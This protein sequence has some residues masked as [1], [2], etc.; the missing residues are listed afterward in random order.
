M[1]PAGTVVITHNDI[2]GAAAAAMVV[3]KCGTDVNNVFPVDYLPDRLAD[4]MEG[5]RRASGEGTTLFLLDITTG[6]SA[7]DTFSGLVRNMK[8]KGAHVAWIDHHDCS[9]RAEAI[10]RQCDLAVVGE[11]RECATELARR[12]L[13]LCGDFEAGLGKLV[14]CADFQVA[15]E[16]EWSVGGS[17]ALD[18]GLGSAETIRA[19][20]YCME[21]INTLGSRKERQ[22]EFRHVVGVLA[23]GRFI[24]ERM[25]ITS[26]RFERL[27]SERIAAMLEG[28]YAIS[29]RISVGFSK[30]VESS[31]ACAE[32][33]A[34]TGADIGI[35]VKD[36]G[37]VSIRCND[38]W[39]IIGLARKLGGGGHPHA[40][41][42]QV[43]RPPSHG[44]EAWRRRL[45]ERIRLKA[46]ELGM[47]A[48]PIC[49]AEPA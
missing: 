3:R 30:A 36:D 38:G 17:G 25:F 42:F 13:R 26:R 34:R 12:Y 5:V 29:G 10:A 18:M 19:Y 2:D 40:A 44:V 48:E 20:G 39:D 31:E 37:N 22:M 23:S 11:S 28:L 32:I 8:G 14:H 21:S 1:K 6:G 35:L 24:D 49:V 16:G 41:G 47:L 46:E 45:V 4:A 27:N 9:C 43:E 15:P 7:A 33:L